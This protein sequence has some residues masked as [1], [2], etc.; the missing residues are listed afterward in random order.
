M[1]KSTKAALLSGLVFPG[2]GHLALKEFFRASILILVATTALYLLTSAAIDQAMSVVDRINSGDVA[3]DAQSISEAVTASSAGTDNRAANASL[4]VFALCWIAGIV[5][6]WR[7]GRI[8]DEIRS[9]P[10]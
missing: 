1:R 6:S 4:L 10:G 3:L 5:D 8:Q 2:I 9:G 7:L